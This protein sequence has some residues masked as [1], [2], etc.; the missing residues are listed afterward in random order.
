MHAWVS[1]SVD[2]ELDSLCTPS[3]ESVCY[4]KLLQISKNGMNYSVFLLKKK[5][6]DCSLLSVIRATNHPF[7][8]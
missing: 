5:F 3:F 1:S 8:D 6:L 2:S 4:V 7:Y